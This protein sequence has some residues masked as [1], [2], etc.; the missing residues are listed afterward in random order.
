MG[1]KTKTNQLLTFIS[2]FGGISVFGLL[3]VIFGPLILTLF[4][5]FLHIYEREYDRVLHDGH[6]SE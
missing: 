6:S 3:G 5:T 4:F 1:G 2:V